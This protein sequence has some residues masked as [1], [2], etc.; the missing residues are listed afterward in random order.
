MT[1]NQLDTL[2]ASVNVTTHTLCFWKI[3]WFLFLL[4]YHFF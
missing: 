3:I 4:S 2:I 1:G